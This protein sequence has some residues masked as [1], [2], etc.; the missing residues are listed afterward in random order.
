MWTLDED[1]DFGKKVLRDS[2]HTSMLR[3]GVK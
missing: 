1:V 2:S 3:F